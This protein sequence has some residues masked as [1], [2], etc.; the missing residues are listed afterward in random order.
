MLI[1]IYWL[2]LVK[3]MGGTAI[4]EF[5]KTKRKSRAAR[6]YKKSLRPT[7]FLYEK[8]NVGSQKSVIKTTT[9]QV[10]IILK[11]YTCNLKSMGRVHIF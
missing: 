6:K 8:K 10:C 7:I 11:L 3:Q 1:P 5:N 2:K 9:F 4:Y